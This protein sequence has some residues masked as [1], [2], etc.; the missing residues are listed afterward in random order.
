MVFTAAPANGSAV[1]VAAGNTGNLVPST[2][3]IN[4]PGICEH[5]LTVGSV[6]LS[7]KA[8]NLSSFSAQ[9]PVRR[10]DALGLGG[11]GSASA[12]HLAGAQAI[13]LDK[14]DVLA[15]GG[16]MSYTA[17]P[18]ACPWPAGQGV[19]SARAAGAGTPWSACAHP[20]EPYTS[21]SGTSMA[22]PVVAGIAALILEHSDR[23]GL[24]VAQ[25]DERAL[26]LHNIIKAGTRDLG[27]ARWQQGYGL[28]DWPLI[29]QILGR[30]GSGRDY[31]DNY[32]DPPPYPR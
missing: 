21:C 17:H 18:G 30:I 27:L 6:D 29:E 14:P 23:N 12:A 8:P 2:S 32:V 4:R 13:T 1:I 31:L 28:V 3:T 26:I 24:G 25:R 16:E 15:P 7:A 10:T 22:A 20:T 9:G 11:V 19:M 5:V